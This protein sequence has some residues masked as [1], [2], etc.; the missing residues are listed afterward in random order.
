MNWLAASGPGS[1][2]P[3]IWIVLGAFVLATV[4]ALIAR[5]FGRR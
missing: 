2:H 3:W 4:A 5:H 1:P